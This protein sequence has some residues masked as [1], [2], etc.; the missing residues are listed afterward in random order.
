MLCRTLILLSLL[1]ISLT[2]Q[3]YA[4]KLDRDYVKG[5]KFTLE[6]DTIFREYETVIEPDNIDKR[7]NEYRKAQNII[8][9]AKIHV[10]D[11]DKDNNVTLL[12]KIINFGA[13]TY[14]PHD[15]D[16]IRGGEKRG[17]IFTTILP[18]GTELTVVLGK[19]DN[20]YLIKGQDV[21][22][23]RDRLNLVFP[24]RSALMPKDNV[25]GTKGKQTLKS[26]WDVNK[27]NCV[28]AF[29][30]KGIKI[31]IK[32][33]NGKSSFTHN[34]PYNGET[35]LTVKS[36]LNISKLGLSD[37]GKD[38]V[39]NATFSMTYEA[40]VPKNHRKMPA[41]SLVVIEQSIKAHNDKER[42]EMKSYLRRQVKRSW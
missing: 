31:E 18:K 9:T 7:P 20:Q 41:Q 11:I 24:V 17:F 36:K 3:E 6:A 34:T 37:L 16:V 14:K 22:K 38:I 32:D 28:E 35:C 5:D 2:A 8:L 39:D 4:I 21:E 27:A 13:L 29:D 19:S 26:S 33:I 23:Y 15:T 12:A 30:A 25:F 10:T 40:A 42:I 1:S